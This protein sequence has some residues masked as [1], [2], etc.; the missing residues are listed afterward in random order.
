M[1][2]KCW[3]MVTHADSGKWFTGYGGYF[4]DS[5]KDYVCNPH[6]EE[7]ELEL[8]LKRFGR[9]RSAANFYL[10]DADGF[11]YQ[12]GMQGFFSLVEAIM[13]DEVEVEK[14]VIKATFRQ[15]KQGTKYFIEPVR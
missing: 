1:G 15:A 4:I 7:R 5:D 3:D 11:S 8:T 10:E 12:L 6:H 14:G 2:K 9:G 13:N